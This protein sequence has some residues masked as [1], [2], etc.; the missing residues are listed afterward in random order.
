MDKV[1]TSISLALRDTETCIAAAVVVELPK[2]GSE[3]DDRRV[4]AVVTHNHLKAV[5]ANDEADDTADVEQ[6]GDARVEEGW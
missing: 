6:D 5:H 1:Q 3:E 2:H 4:L